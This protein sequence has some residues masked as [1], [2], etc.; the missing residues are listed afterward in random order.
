MRRCAAEYALTA[1]IYWNFNGTGYFIIHEAFITLKK[2]VRKPILSGMHA[3][4]SA[5][6]RQKVNG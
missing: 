6:Y 5:M 3:G 4:K 1:I 2:W